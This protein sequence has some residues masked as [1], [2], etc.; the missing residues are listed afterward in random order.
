MAEQSLQD[1]ASKLAEEIERKRD[2]EERKNKT[3]KMGF[4]YGV[5]SEA[6][7]VK[8]LKLKMKAEYYLPPAGPI[9]WFP[10]KDDVCRSAVGDTS[11]LTSRMKE[12]YNAD[13]QMFSTCPSPWDDEWLAKFGDREKGQTFPQ[14]MEDEDK[15]IPCGEA[16][17]HIYLCPV[18]KDYSPLLIKSMVNVIRGFCY[19][20]RIHEL[21]YVPIDPSWFYNVHD[22]MSDDDGDDGSSEDEESME[23]DGLED[24]LVEDE[25]AKWQREVKRKFERRKREEARARKVRHRR[26][27]KMA[28]RSADRV[29]GCVTPVLDYLRNK[30]NHDWHGADNAYIVIA[31]STYE[32]VDPH[33][34]SKVDI[35]I[36]AL[37]RKA[38]TI[39]MEEIEPHRKV[40]AEAIMQGK[41]ARAQA[42]AK[43]KKLADKLQKV[44]H[45]I[46]ALYKEAEKAWEGLEEKIVPKDRVGVM[47]IAY[48][49]PLFGMSAAEKRRANSN[50]RKD[51]N[52]ETLIRRSCKRLTHTFGHL[53]GLEHCIY[54]HCRMNGCLTTSEQEESPCYLC[55]V[56]LRKLHNAIGIHTTRRVIERY[57]ENRKFY[58]GIWRKAFGPEVEN[59]YKERI[60]RIERCVD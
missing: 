40:L 36:E 54:Y 45:G 41:A 47:S 38:N 32:M 23:A 24:L 28:A 56:C 2:A 26:R 42:L 6:S 20:C 11:G 10:P 31:I 58:G 9:K 16:R 53:L 8:K 22:W 57:Y 1:E 12:V 49:D 14:W 18:G 43:E 37:Q 3:K 59:W 30:L 51:E 21:P 5:V 60:A 7:A 13:S 27:K 29:K 34:A 44:K 19:G 52:T 17:S 33:A 39:K 25:K 35:E 46:E 55:A 15:K 50:G 48:M 4:M